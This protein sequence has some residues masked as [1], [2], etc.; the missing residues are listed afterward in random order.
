MHPDRHPRRI[1]HGHEEGG[2]IP[3]G[4][5]ISK[6]THRSLIVCVP[7]RFKGTDYGKDGEIAEM[8]R[9]FDTNLKTLF[10]PST[11]KPVRINHHLH[12]KDDANL[13]LKRGYPILTV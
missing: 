2:N 10:S 3:Q 11:N 12:S 8:L 7:G 13:R 4:Y 6:I 9:D 1:N 5:V